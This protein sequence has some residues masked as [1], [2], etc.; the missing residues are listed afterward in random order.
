MVIS[1]EYVDYQLTAPSCSLKRSNYRNQDPS[2]IPYLIAPES[3]VDDFYPTDLT[4][5]NEPFIVKDVRGLS[6]YV[7]A[8]QYNAVQQ[9]LRVYKNVIVELTENNSAPPSTH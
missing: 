4:F 3:L 7:Q 6:V 8:F 5:T 1:S 9:V 2:K